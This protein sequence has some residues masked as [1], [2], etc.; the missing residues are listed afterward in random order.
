MPVR[1]V[2]FDLGGTLIRRYGPEYEDDNAE[3]LARWLRNRNITVDETF[4]TALVAERQSRF[5]NRRGLREVLA[6]DA[7]RPVLLRYG[8]QVD[9]EFLAQ[10]EAAFFEPELRAMRPLP[11]AVNVLRQ[12]PILGLLVGLASNA[13]SDYFVVECCRRLGFAP[14]LEPIVSSAAVGWSKPDPRIFQAIL[15]EW[16]LP[17][18]SVTMVGDYLEADIAGGHRMGM[19]TVLLTAEHGPLDAAASDAVRPDVIAHDLGEVGRIIGEWSR[20]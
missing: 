15:T 1:G 8:V 13:S 7:L 19:R 5:A 4:V 3:A 2:I 18:A 16:K 17:A 6:E 20:S 9:P 14:Y 10:A 11:E 12:L